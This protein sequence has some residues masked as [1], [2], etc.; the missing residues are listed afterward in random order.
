MNGIDFILSVSLH[1]TSLIVRHMQFLSCEYW[2]HGKDA[3]WPL[4]LSRP[5]Q[6]LVGK[7]LD[8]L[9]DVWLKNIPNEAHKLQYGIRFYGACK[10]MFTFY[11]QLILIRLKHQIQ[12]N[13]FDEDATQTRHK[14]SSTAF[15]RC[16]L[17]ITGGGC[18]SIFLCLLTV[19]VEAPPYGKGT[20]YAKFINDLWVLFH[21]ERLRNGS[22]NSF[23]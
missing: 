23:S 13:H 6:L 14:E 16:P 21:S 17:S 15:I 18:R 12:L 5:D 22:V 9:K 2:D 10:S 4:K 11:T 19:S 1:S 20:E 8:T 3:T 7:I